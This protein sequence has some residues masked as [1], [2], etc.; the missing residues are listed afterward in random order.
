MPLRG[1]LAQQ[2]SH[3]RLCQPQHRPDAGLETT[4][5]TQKRKSGR[6]PADPVLLAHV[7][8]DYT[9]ARKRGWKIHLYIKGEMRRRN[10]KDIDPGQ[11]IK[12]ARD[13]GYLTP[14]EKS[15]QIGGK[16]TQKAIDTLKESGYLNSKGER[17]D[18]QEGTTE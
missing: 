11:W 13:R 12:K 4:R 18:E 14:T 17:P 9:E 7:A 10:R 16:T 3:R 8:Y 6:P 15:G 2:I 5:Q 1:Y